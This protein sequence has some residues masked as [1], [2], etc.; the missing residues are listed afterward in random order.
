[1][2]RMVVVTWWQV[3]SRVRCD[4]YDI[5]EEDGG[6][7][8]GGDYNSMKD[9]ISMWASFVTLLAQLSECQKQQDM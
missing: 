3:P 2:R 9:A 1:M 8:P 6:Q 4:R 7:D 5:D